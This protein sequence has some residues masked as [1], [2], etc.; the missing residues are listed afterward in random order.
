MAPNVADKGG[1]AQSM[2]KTRTRRLQWWWRLEV[3]VVAVNR[4]GGGRNTLARV[5]VAAPS[6]LSPIDEEGTGLSPV[7]TTTFNEWQF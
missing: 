2:E 7:Q 3:V 5:K 1:S 4:G 6:V